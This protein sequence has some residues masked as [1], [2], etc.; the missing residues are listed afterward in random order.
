M[1]K[2]GRIQLI[3]TTIA[4]I[5]IVL[6]L[7][8]LTF[9]ALQVNIARRQFSHAQQG[10]LAEH[11]RLRRKATVDF[12]MEGVEYRNRWRTIAPNDWN[13]EVTARFIQQSFDDSNGAALRELA[14]FFGYL[15]TMAVGTAAGVYDLGTIDAL[16]GDW[17]VAIAKNYKPY[18]ERVRITSGAPALYVEFEWL[19]RRLKEI[20]PSGSEYILV[21]NRNT[22]APPG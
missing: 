3:A 2:L 8:G 11:A 1:G 13:E 10:V 14:T 18:L 16:A 17:V 20:R 5:G 4:V 21:A 19:A 7:A 22:I 12:F 6:N 15:E 9:V